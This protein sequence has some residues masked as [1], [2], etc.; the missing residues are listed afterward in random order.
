MFTILRK[1]PLNQIISWLVLASFLNLIHGCYYL[2]INKT[3][4]PPAQEV[5]RLQNENKSFILH[6]NTNVWSFRNITAGED[7]VKGIVTELSGPVK[8]YSLENGKIHRYNISDSLKKKDILNE[9]HIYADTVYLSSD[10][11]ASFPVTDVKEI[12]VYDPARGT[13]TAS[14][15]LGTLGSVVAAIAIVGIIV[16]LTK[17]SCPFIYVNDDTS[18]VFVGEIYSGAIYPSLERPDYLPLPPPKPGQKDYTIRMTNEVHEI[19]NTNLIE[20]NVID[21]PKGTRA[22]IDKYGNCQ[23]VSLMQSPISA[24]DLSGKDILET[25]TKKDS[26]SLSTTQPVKDAPLANGIIMTFKRPA[27]SN[28]AKLVVNARTTYWLDYTFTRFH[29]LFGKEYDCWVDK[30]QNVSPD[31][32]KKW[33]LDQ[34]IP[35]SLFVEKNGKWKFIDYYNIVGPMALKEDILSFDISDI[36]SDELKIKLEY[37]NLFWEVDYAGVDYSLNVPVTMRI[38]RLNSAIDNKE[39]DVANLISSADMLYYVQPEIGDAVNMNFIL[40]D[41]VDSEQTLILHSQ[42]HYRILLNLTGEQKKKELLTFMKKGRFPEFS[43]EILSDHM[44]S[45]QR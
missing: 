2:R 41:P 31:K 29:A 36:K 6:Q 8:S 42:G 25:I 18:S 21:H 15:V 45:A 10:S 33:M 12:H 23:T 37:G 9:V 32:M 35:L 38:A 13:T 11:V 14:W 44:A 26:L 7:S 39:K 19:Q 22:Y 43:G 3:T 4:G 30:Q 1:R 24:T 27:N 17:E 34:N 20:L 16:A 5:S 40:P 28:I